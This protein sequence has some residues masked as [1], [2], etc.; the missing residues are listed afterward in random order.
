VMFLFCLNSWGS[1][2][3]G[4]LRVSASLLSVGV[5]VC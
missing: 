1:Q 2:V 3:C 4:S 5:L